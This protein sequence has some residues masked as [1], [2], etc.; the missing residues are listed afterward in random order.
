MKITKNQLRKIIKEELEE[1][2]TE[3]MSQG[4]MPDEDEA[5]ELFAELKEFEMRLVND[6]PGLYYRPA[7]GVEGKKTMSYYIQN[8]LELLRNLRGRNA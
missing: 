5:N 8:A 4:R 7:G 6:F 2:N 3:A 1:L